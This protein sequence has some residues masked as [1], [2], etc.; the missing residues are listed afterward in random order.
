MAKN[1]VIVESPAKAK[2]LKKFLGSNYKIEASMGHVRD[3][4]KSELGID[5]ENDYTP[6]Y[7]TIRGKG[8]L[9]A[10]LRKEVK[11]ADKIFLAT[12]PDREG[13]AISWHLITALKLEGKKVFRISFNEI[14]KVAVKNSIKEAREIDMDLVNSQQAR[15]ALDRIVGYKISPLLWAKVKKGLSAGR[16]QS[17]TLKVIC[18]RE[19]DIANF[20]Q[21][22]YW[23]IDFELKHKRTAFKGRLYGDKNGKIELK[24]EDDVK[25]VVARL[26]Q[27]SLEVIEVKKSKRVKNTYPPFTTSTLQQEGSKSLNFATSKTMKIAQELYEGVDIKGEG[28]V[29]LVSYIRTDSVR[30]SDDAYESCNTFVKENY[31]EEYIPQERNVYKSKGRAQDAHEAIRPT[32]VNKTPDS[33]KGSLSK[34]QYKLYSLIWNRFVASQMKK[35]QYDTLAVTIKSGDILIRTSGSI[36]TF[37]G[38][39]RVYKTEEEKSDKDIKIP[40]LTKGDKVDLVDIIKEQHFTQP[41]GRYSE[42]SLVKKLEDLGIGRPST[43]APTIATIINRGYVTRDNK[44]LFPTELGEIV[45]EIMT[46]NFA[47]VVDIDFTAKMEGNLDKVELG[48]LEWKEVLR[49]FYPPFNEQMIVA[50]E[51]ISKIEIKDEVTDVICEHCGKNMV[52]KYGRHGKFLACPGF[53]D[54]RNAKPFYEEAGVDCPLCSGKV[55]YKKSKK[56]R[57]YFGCENGPECEFMSWYKP[58]G[59]KCPVCSSALVEKGKKDTRIVC[60]N[61]QCDYVKGFKEDIESLEEK[62]DVSS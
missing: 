9:L 15:R 14:T 33:I 23:S 62:E 31:G 17:V 48:E 19:E 43:Y 26:D 60:D 41:P 10:K 21:E 22:E 18:D 27:K 44:V 59:E 32:Y 47:E 55:I 11:K 29:G 24:N 42:A 13:E 30:I 51:A 5:F 40:V 37:D 49:D 53:P 56:G 50:E 6:K 38:F 52:V 34:D 25:K 1:L 35:A 4:P 39:L 57:R 2:T 46:N 16:V 54:C 28:T 20:V 58:T 36:L 12:D 45:N 7:I 61:G 3:L 8:E